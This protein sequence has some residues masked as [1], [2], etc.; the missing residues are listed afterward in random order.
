MVGVAKRTDTRPISVARESQQTAA[1]VVTLGVETR[2]ISMALS[3]F[4]L[5][6]IDVC[7]TH[8]H[9]YQSHSQKIFIFHAKAKFLGQKLAAKNEKYIS[10]F[11]KRT[12]PSMKARRLAYL[13]QHIN[14][15]LYAGNHRKMLAIT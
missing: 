14:T 6:L 9:A 10:V 13:E 7:I 12:R 2:R 3:R 15:C 4:H 5:T 8:S 11:I 1:L